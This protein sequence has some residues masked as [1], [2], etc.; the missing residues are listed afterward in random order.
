MIET[1]DAQGRLRNRLPVAIIDIGSN[2]VR[3]VIYEGLVRAP[4]MLF[5]EKVQCGLGRGIAETGDMD[6]GAVEAALAALR[7]FRALADQ[8]RVERLVVLATA[9]AREAGNG[10]A[11]IAEAERILRQDITVLSGR[12]EALYSAYGVQSAFRDI[13]GVTGDLG[14]GSLEL[15]E[16]KGEEIG[17]GKTL[18]IG[19]IR[20]S[21]RSGEDLDKAV[22]IARADIKTVPFLKEGEGRNF[23][24][25]GGTWRNLA[26]LHMASQDYPLHVTHHYEM[27][28]AN[29]LGFLTKVGRNNVEKLRGIEDVSR[30]RRALLPYGAIALA[31]VIRV[32]KP[33]KVIFSSAGVREGYLFSLLD[34]ETRR[35]DA[36]IE[37]SE[38]LSIL[39]SR[40]PRHARELAA[41]TGKAFAAFGI[42]ETEDEARYREAAC[43]LADISWR[44]HPDYRGYQALNVIAY[45]SFA[46]VD[47]PGRAYIALANYFR[48]DGLKNPTLA[49]EIRK[50]IS[51]RIWERSRFLGAFFRVAYLFTAAMPGVIGDVTWRE[52]DDKTM[53]LVIPARLAELAGSRPL[54]R[55]G[56]LAKTVNREIVLVID[57]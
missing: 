56:Q 54:G 16:V 1:E 46:Q 43:R 18:P 20:L 57:V 33:A 37:A 6:A 55:I 11:F 21:E 39:R 30:S 48:H 5:N 19:G 4:S 14:G 36:L 25:V 32:M 51:D 31:E 41:W 12:E 22:E 28:A 9:A 40:S 45:G 52:R 2:S 26:K 13:D 27:D 38:E 50:I 49:P 17:D 10:P 53:E 44:A 8:A 34:E 47:H 24:A 42:D 7:R 3:L 29:A 23:Y 35:T 15:V